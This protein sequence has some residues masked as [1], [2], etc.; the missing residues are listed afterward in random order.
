[1]RHCSTEASG[2][3][4][5]IVSAGL[6]PAG[7]RI[8]FRLTLATLLLAAAIFGGLVIAVAQAQDAD[9]AITGLTLSSDTPGELVV[10]WDTPSPEP[11]DYRVDW[12]KSGESYQSYTVDEGH[13]YPAGSATTVAITGLEAGAEYKV[14]MRARYHD[15]EHADRPWS[16]PWAEAAPVMVARPEP[17]PT[18][19]PTPEPTS[20]PTPEPD[21]GEAS[22]QPPA[23]PRGLVAAAE[24]GGVRLSWDDPADATVTHY[25]IQR[26]LADAPEE[27]FVV[28]AFYG[29]SPIT[30]YL[31]PAAGGLSYVYRVQAINAQGQGPPGEVP[32]ETP[33]GRLRVALEAELEVGVKGDDNPTRGYGNWL[34]IGAWRVLRS[35]WGLN[36]NTVNT[37]VHQPHEERRVVLVVTQLIDAPFILW[38]DGHP[39]PAAN[40]ERRTVNGYAYLW[41]EQCLDWPAGETV[42]VQIEVSAADDPRLGQ[43]QDAS[44]SGLELE[45]AQL[46]PAFD[47]DTLQYIAEADPGAGLVTVRARAARA[48]AC[49]LSIS[50]DDSSA[51]RPGWQVP[52]GPDDQVVTI[53][54]TAPDGVSERSYTVTIV[55]DGAEGAGLRG[56]QVVG[57]PALDFTSDQERYQV[58]LPAGAT[59]VEVEP[60]ANTEDDPVDA[61]SVR[62]ERFVVETRDPEQPVT[63]S[64]RGD[65]LVFIRARSGDGRHE[66]QYR[67]RLRPPQPRSSQ[68]GEGELADALAP[69][70]DTDQSSRRSGD[71]QQSSDEPRLTGLTIERGAIAPDFDPETFSYAV[72][73]GRD[74]SR[75]TVTPSVGGGA[76]LLFQPPDAD[77]DAA[78]HQVWLDD[79][80]RDAPSET[81]IT[82]IVR[83]PDG[84]KLDS[85]QLR[86]TRS[87]HDDDASLSSL[88][89][90]DAELS[91]TFSA[92]VTQYTVT[93]IEDTLTVAPM[94]T[95]AGANPVIMPPDADDSTDGH[96]VSLAL[97]DT[98]V[99]I[100][101]TAEDGTTVQEYVIV[102]TRTLPP[103]R[104]DECPV[105]H[106]PPTPVAVTEAPIKVPS[107]TADYFVLYVRHELNADTTVEVPVLVKRGEA[108]TTTLAESVAALPAERYQ[109]EKY[110]VADPA[111]IDGDC[112]DDLTELDNLGSMNP[113]NPAP[114]I[115]IINGAVAIPDR[116]AFET[117][118]F[119]TRSKRFDRIEIAKFFLFDMDTDRPSVYFA[120]TEIHVTHQS[121]LDAIGLEWD[122]GVFFGQ[123][124]YYPKLVAPDG[125]PGV[126]VLR[127]DYPYIGSFRARTYTVIAA[128]M[129]LLEDNLA[130]HVPNYKLPYLQSILPL[131]R[132]SRMN[133]VFDEDIEAETSFLALNP[134]EGY[135]R[136]QALEPDE[137]PHPRDVVIYEALP[138]ELPRVAGIIST[139]PQTLLSHVNLRA[140]QDG[141]PNAFIRDALDKHSVEFLLGGFVR[142]EVT[143]SG[144]TLSAATPEEVNAHY[145]SSRPAREQT[146]QR[147][148][149]V[150]SI[151]P[152]SEIGFADWDAFGVKAAN[153]AV[154][155]TLGFPTG[156]VP[157]G[158]AIPFYFYD[159]FM[160]AN[161]LYNDIKEMLADPDFQTDFDKQAD[162]LK[163]LRKKIK[164]GATP[165]WIITALEEMH[166]T[167][168]AGQSLRYRSST[169]SEDLP[170]FNGAGLYDSKTQKPDETEEDGI[171]KSLKQVFAS[172]WN[173]RAFTER[174]FHRIDHLSTAMGVLVHPNYSDELANGVAV[175]FDPVRGR[176]E[177]YYVNT[178]VGEDLVTNPEAHSVP[179][180]ILLNQSGSYTV[181]WT[182]NQVPPGQ[183]LLSYDQVRQL[184]QRLTMI[185]DQFALLYGVE[186]DDPFAMEI[187]FKIT[188]DNILAIKQARPWVFGPR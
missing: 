31:D 22:L 56:L 170:G 133:L 42:S 95:S 102:V 88:G 184:R 27:E 117:L 15:G 119:Q 68:F 172:L 16:G 45:G 160:K 59:E 129:P 4:H 127:D 18:P 67:L 63:V 60:V 28:R 41:P 106:A 32:A 29:D 120:N 108:G 66:R 58:P 128:S 103:Q 104:E 65:T 74:V 122:A 94:T 6:S 61:F 130:F 139:V 44:L 101:V 97:G 187:E 141:I 89:V 159:E 40:A 112:I 109:V 152:L 163:K 50:P 21:E 168:P 24:P 177:A 115:D 178:Q 149:S 52:A 174:E 62:A 87:S 17:T 57:L 162:K 13:V 153:V 93:V 100:T 76:G 99:T 14:R 30:T 71:G 20:G 55:G 72:T 167:Y 173:F 7:F 37:L 38:L 79:A 134:G 98:T 10:S 146:P 54:V 166:A 64:E 176:D 132:A 51:A 107:T 126:Y 3:F 138:N 180:E 158:H 77:L 135:G 171:D 19:E 80:R 105:I 34:K 25:R 123:I 154:L 11:T 182:S 131:H 2:L 116:S 69:I 90:G 183:L 151:T 91:P 85:Y 157:D 83:S 9:G 136:L 143:E 5:R 145:E 75:L 36:L 181:L 155:G 114:A 23:A 1:M 113:V 48:A 169:N 118:A 110:Q 121:L 46:E 140:V 125:S 12:A 35:D 49:G 73:V 96:Q 43:L 147:D 33:P 111:D 175:S 179:E 156:T 81:T 78:G 39:L 188:S 185:H 142:Y 82:I 86:I 70:L 26:R 186:D 47:P 84:R 164:K 144:W 8:E 53:T 92:T 124:H 165:A 137:R 148:L 161:D 150:T